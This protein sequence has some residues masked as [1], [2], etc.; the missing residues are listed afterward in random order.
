MKANI[1]HHILMTVMMMMTMKIG[2]KV[3]CTIIQCDELSNNFC[4]PYIKSYIC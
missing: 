4:M 3:I 2:G 1:P